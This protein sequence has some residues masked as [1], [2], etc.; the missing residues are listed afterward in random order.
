M[1]TQADCITLATVGVGSINMHVQVSLL[2]DA[3]IT[4]D[5]YAGMALL[6]VLFSAFFF[7][8][9]LHT[10]FHNGKTSSYPD[11]SSANVPAP[12]VLASIFVSSFA[13]FSW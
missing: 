10:E 4:S 8:R 2:C 1:E 7:F 9:H 6:V 13:F 5:I 11:Q 12:C 3:F